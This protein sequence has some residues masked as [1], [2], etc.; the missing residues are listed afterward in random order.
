MTPEHKALVAELVAE[1]DAIDRFGFNDGTADVIRKAV[2]ALESLSAENAELRARLERAEDKIA[3]ALL[4]ERE[5]AAEEHRTF[6]QKWAAKRLE[7]SRTQWLR[8]AKRALDGDMR[9]LRLRVELAEAPP[10]QIVCSDATAILNDGGR[11][12]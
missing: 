2:A 4:A 10:V 3:R 11:D 9:D 5:R 6:W 7:I 1:A 8:A 12:G